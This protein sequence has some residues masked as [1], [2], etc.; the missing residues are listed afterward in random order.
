MDRS[1]HPMTE[2]RSNNSRS[3]YRPGESRTREFSTIKRK[4]TDGNRCFNKIYI[5]F[6]ISL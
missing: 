3:N 6:R 4:K 1:D 2:L 5:E